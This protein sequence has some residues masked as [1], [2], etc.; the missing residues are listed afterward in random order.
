[1]TVELLLMIHLFSS[2]YVLKCL[3][4][5]CTFLTAGILGSFISVRCLYF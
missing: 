1:M 3:L 4:A 5:G 2:C